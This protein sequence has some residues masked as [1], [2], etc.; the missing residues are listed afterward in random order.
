MTT[1]TKEQAIKEYNKIAKF[2]TDAMDLFIENRDEVKTINELIEKHGKKF[3]LAISV[4]A[5]IKLQDA[6]EKH[7]AENALK[8]INKK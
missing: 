3:G 4:L 1:I 5:Q 2:T 8:D 7:L 6:I